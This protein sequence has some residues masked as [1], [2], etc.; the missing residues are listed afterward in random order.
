MQRNA[1]KLSVHISKWPFFKYI[2]TI[3]YEYLFEDQ[4]IVFE[5]VSKNLNR[6]LGLYF[7]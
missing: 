2:Y 5:N 3:A 7:F 1:N 4:I 6:V